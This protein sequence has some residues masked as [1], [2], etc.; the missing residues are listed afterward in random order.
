MTSSSPATGR[1]ILT[2]DLR[3]RF[4]EPPDV[5]ARTLTCSSSGRV[6]PVIADDHR[7]AGL[8]GCGTSRIGL[9]GVEYG[10]R[11]RYCRIF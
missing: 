3:A 11:G 10:I 4:D 7:W 9:Q 6:G 2:T 8:V 1:T 5:K